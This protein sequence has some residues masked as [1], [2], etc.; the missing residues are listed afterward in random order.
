[1][2]FIYIS[3][4]FP[5]VYYQFPLTAKKIGITTLGIAEDSYEALSNELK[6]ALTDYY[7]VS[8]LENYDEV[9]KAVA[10]FS[11]KYGKIDYLESN[12]EYWLSQD[13]RLRTDFNITSS[14]NTQDLSSFKFKSGMKSYY[15]N[16][17]VQTARYT[18]VTDIESAKKFIEEVEYP[19][20]VKPDNGV[21]A[22]A[23]YKLSNEKE[24][25]KF[26]SEIRTVQYIME[27][28]LEGD[29]ISYDGIVGN[30]SEI[31]FE[32]SHFFTTPVMEIVNEA[33]EC[34]YY[35]LKEIPEKLRKLGQATIKSF[36]PRNR[37][38]HLEFFKLSKDKKGVG[39][40]GDYIGLEVN[41]R[42]HGGYTTDMMNFANDI[43]VYQIY[44]ET[45][46][47]GTSYYNTK[48]PY[49]CVHVGRR[50]AIKYKNN[51]NYLK[52]KYEKNLC[53]HETMPQIIADALGNEVFVARFKT[54]KELNEFIE[55]T[56]ERQ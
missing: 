5:K 42:P 52:A 14:Y 38:F 13:A 23:T 6:E 10:Y 47:Y 55:K 50:N 32:T 16:A 8:S 35:S 3:P 29:I 7:Q 45:L 17:G 34:V 26:F 25:I 37:F 12:N 46:K 40:K 15:K 18:L 27:E 53:M 30:N 31:I 1:M 43:D 33:K 9:F 24:L 19:I 54:Q 2:N 49:Y 36:K 39:K 21:G 11:F 44:A 48:R 4:T 22:N 56:L 20:I 41:M 28:F 51:Y